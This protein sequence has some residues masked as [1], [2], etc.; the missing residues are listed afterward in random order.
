MR[1]IGSILLLIGLGSLLSGCGLLPSHPPVKVLSSPRVEV[2]AAM[3]DARA[4]QQKAAAQVNTIVRTITDPVTKK[5]VQ[6][7][8]QTIND[9]GL[10][11]ETATGKI[12]WYTAQ[13]DLVVGQRDWWQRKAESEEVR[14]IQAEKERDALVWIFAA[15][16]GTVLVAGAGKVVGSWFGVPWN[17]LSIAGLFVIGF[18]IGFS[19]GR[20]ALH[21]L[22]KF[23]PHL[24]W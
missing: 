17:F 5:A 2:D 1:S 8:Q 3:S 21:F 12:A 9:L 24:P 16:C 22:S 20:W 15:A 10:K 18:S 13:Y 11:L 7:L 4:T 23:T 6:D 19:I 14:K